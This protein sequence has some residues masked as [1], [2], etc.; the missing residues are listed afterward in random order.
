M[1][2]TKHKSEIHGDR[3]PW[4][5][6]LKFYLPLAATSV[7]MMVTHSVVSSAMTKTLSPAI[8]LAGY[9]AAY[10][11][12]QVFEAPCYG[13]QRMALTFVSGKRSFRVVAK[14]ALWI[15]ATVAGGL[16]LISWTPLSK[17]V[18]TRVLGLGEE[19]Y[20]AALPSL[21]VFI[22]WPIS[23]AV[24][25]LYQSL[26]VLRK[27][28]GWLT[29]NMVARVCLMLL[30]AFLL[31][32]IWPG[33][34]VGAS[35][36]MLGLCTE[37]LLAFVVSRK[38]IPPLGEDSPEGAE[39][40]TGQVLAFTLPLGLAAS[41]QTLARP[42]VTAALSRTMSPEVTLAGYQVANSFSYISLALTYNIYHAVVIF[43]KDGTS[44]G[45]IRAFVIGLGLTGSVVLS[46]CNIPAVGN[47]VFGTVIGATPDIA[48]EAMRT[49]MTLAITPMLFAL[50]EFYSGMLML[51]KHSVWVTGAKMANVAATSVA[52]LALA[53]LFPGLGGAA[54]ALALSFGGAVEGVLN[55]VMFKRT[56]EYRTYVLSGTTGDD[57]RVS[58]G[59]PV[60]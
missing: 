51:A 43:I 7:L 8:A 11:V 9:S 14:T 44:F 36:L 20:R 32:K 34:P 16:L 3:I 60:T 49:L 10:S 24:R 12:G 42:V 59:R 27:K 29:V 55:Y 38:A 41:V 33:G 2:M 26:I 17:V 31:P 28:T 13:M 4:V 56:G 19:A 46:I 52:V 22:L 23:S 58:S 54:G 57:R 5:Q 18:F 6:V 39:I 15:L 25:S 1:M 50:V 45:Q 21:R 30:S 37:A 47:W 53:R 48:R 40:T 35:I